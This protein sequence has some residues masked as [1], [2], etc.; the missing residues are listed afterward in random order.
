MD[1][2]P[3]LE[4]VEPGRDALNPPICILVGVEDELDGRINLQLPLQGEQ[5]LLPRT[6]AL[7]E[8]QHLP[9]GVHLR[10]ET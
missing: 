7:R 3:V 6:P 4:S 8:Q 9:A 10:A 5:V 2:A 1:V